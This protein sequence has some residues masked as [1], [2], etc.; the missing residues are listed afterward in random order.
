V[1]AALANPE[2]TLIIEGYP[3]YH[4]RFTGITV[5]ATQVTTPPLQAV[6]RQQQTT[7]E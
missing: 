4:L 6:K 3:I 2:D 1:T 7:A 5:Y